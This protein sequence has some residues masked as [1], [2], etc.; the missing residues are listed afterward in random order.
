V[1]K[2]LETAEKVKGERYLGDDPQSGKPVY[3]RMGR[4]GPMVQIGQADG[5]E[6][7]R[8][9]KL[10]KDQSIE[11][12]TLDE[13]LELFKLPRNIGEIN[14]K[15]VIIQIGRYGPYALY[16]GKFYSLRKDMDPYT[17]ELDE[18]AAWIAEKQADS[19]KKIIKQF[20]GTDIQILRGPY[21]PYLKKGKQNYRLPKEWQDK[22]E[23]LSLEECEQII[24]SA[25]T[26]GKT[27]RA[28][29]R[30]TPSKK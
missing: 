16:D 3:A 22:P 23:Q 6:K 15:E 30:N 10:K 26:S 2:T 14:G 28:A 9:A 18:V 4:Y 5:Q 17:V 25:A 12:I 13:A 19:D 27:R 21:G 11:T 8:F 29:R 20:D 24:Q 7:P 1:E